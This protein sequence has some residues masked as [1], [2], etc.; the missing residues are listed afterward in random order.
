MAI[1]GHSSRRLVTEPRLGRR[2]PISDR[3][4]RDE[5]LRG[6]SA[7]RKSLPPKLFYDDAGAKLF[8]Q[9]CEQ[10]EYYITPVETEI[11]GQRAPEIARLAGPRPA[12][13]EYGSGA[14]RKVRLLLNALDRPIAY[15]P[16]DISRD[17]L[18]RV[19]TA[20]QDAYPALVVRPVWADYTR[21]FRLP[22]LPAGSPRIAFF[23][24]S[25]IGNFHPPEAAAFLRSLRSVIGYDGSLILGVDRAKDRATLDAAYNDAAGVTARFNLNLLE[26]LNRELD[27]DF[28]LPRFRHR[29]WYNEELKRIEMHLESLCDQIVSVSGSAIPFRTGETVLTECSYKYDAESLDRLTTGAGFDVEQLWT[30]ANDLF[31]VAYLRCNRRRS[32]RDE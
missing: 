29:A 1:H 12:L 23:P 30:D 11:L 5:V 18:S 31:W 16:V 7:A 13:V 6:L 4:L 3:A 15:V 8:E 19:A 10:P 17:Q 9:I 32:D 14:G 2:A 20:I 25:T 27:A 26:R 28:D 21:R 24:G 22:H